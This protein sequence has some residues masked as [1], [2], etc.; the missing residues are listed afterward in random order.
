MGNVIQSEN[1]KMLVSAMLSLK[2]ERQCCDF[3][4][5]LMTQ[6]EIISLGQRLAVATRLCRHDKYSQI[7]ESTGASTATIGRVKRCVDYGTGGY[8][9]V[10]E[11][12]G[13]LDAEE[14]HES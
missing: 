2:D 4:E 8:R 9:A 10:L 3:I 12:L 6:G 5:D 7:A 1:T 14:P 11:N 13:V